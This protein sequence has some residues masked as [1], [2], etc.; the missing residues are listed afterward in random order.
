L[1]QELIQALFGNKQLSEEAALVEVQNGAGADGLG[2]QVVDYLVGFGFSSASL[3]TANPVD[4]AIRPL[5]Q[6]IDFSDKEYTVERLASLLSVPPG[7]VRHAGA[8]DYALRMVEEADVVVILGTDA[9]A[10][11]FA[12]GTSGG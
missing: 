5:T 7:Q 11:D 9:Q 4:G 10:R 3:A 12:A 1:V 8:D 2:Q 6:I